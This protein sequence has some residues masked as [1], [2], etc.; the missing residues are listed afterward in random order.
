MNPD[1]I[2]CNNCGK[3]MVGDE[4]IEPLHCPYAEIFNPRIAPGAG[5]VHCTRPVDHK[6][7]YYA[8]TGVGRSREDSQKGKP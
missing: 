4:I 1:K 6:V 3:H 7:G 8:F 5:P 2:T